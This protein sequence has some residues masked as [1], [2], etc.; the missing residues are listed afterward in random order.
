MT[1]SI[2]LLEELYSKEASM[3]IFTPPLSGGT[4]TEEIDD[5]DTLRMQKLKLMYP[6]VV[7]PRAKNKI[8]YIIII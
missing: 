4:L 2:P 5:I 3:L 1:N 7:C 8:F 6:L